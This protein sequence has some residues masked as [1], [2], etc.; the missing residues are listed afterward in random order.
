[1]DKE[2]NPILV[3]ITQYSLCRPDKGVNSSRCKCRTKYFFLAPRSDTSFPEL[4][5]ILLCPKCGI[6]RIP[7]IGFSSEPDK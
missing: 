6:V 4:P 3:D 7:S 1:M 5:L 2:E